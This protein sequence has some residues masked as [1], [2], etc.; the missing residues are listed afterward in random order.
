MN[1]FTVCLNESVPGYYDNHSIQ[2][3]AGMS[4]CQLFPC[5]GNVRNDLK[6]GHHLGN[7]EHLLDIVGHC[8]QYAGPFQAG[9]MLLKLDCFLEMIPPK[10]L[11]QIRRHRIYRPDELFSNRILTPHKN[12]YPI[13]HQMTIQ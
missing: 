3:S 11:T 8:A 1:H 9:Y 5:H 12:H 2:S 7:S 10:S 4:S 13:N 6:Q